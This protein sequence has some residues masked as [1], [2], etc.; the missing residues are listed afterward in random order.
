METLEPLSQER[1]REILISH[2]KHPR[3]QK[4]L[5]TPYQATIRNPICGDEVT[6]K[7][8]LMQTFSATQLQVADVAVS[9]QACAIC[10]AS[11]SLLSETIK[12]F[13]ASQAMSISKLFQKHLTDAELIYSKWPLEL[14]ELQAF[15]HLKI[16][17]TRLSCGILP[18]ICMEKILAD[19]LR[20]QI[21]T[22]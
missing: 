20:I 16:N 7:I 1:A 19:A 21:D 2:S 9:T 8:H 15:E 18:W 17:K 11:T 14:R 4:S 5:E 3:N 10:T 13:T 6:L 12:G 22:K